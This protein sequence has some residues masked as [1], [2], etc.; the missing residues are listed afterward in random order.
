L[1]ASNGTATF[2]SAGQNFINTLGVY[3]NFMVVSGIPKDSGVSRKR[4]NL[5]HAT[6]M[7]LE[8]IRDN[9]DLLSWD[10]S[11]SFDDEGKSRSSGGC[12]GFQI[13]GYFG[14]IDARPKG[15]CTLELWEFPPTGKGRIVEII[16]LRNKKTVNTDN[17]RLLHIYRRKANVGW[18]QVLTELLGFLKKK[19]CAEVMIYHR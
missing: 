18:D 10:Y 9:L 5:L 12:S 11:Y 1:D 7:L 3:D 17:R 15:F 16:D 4:S 2:I 14:S 6:D 13:R 19:K 8:N